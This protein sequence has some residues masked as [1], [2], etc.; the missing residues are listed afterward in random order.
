MKTFAF[1][2]HADNIRQVREFWPITRIVPDFFINRFLKN[3]D[4]KVVHIKSLKSSTNEEVQGYFI[5]S[6]ALPKT[7]ED[8]DMEHKEE[9]VLD[10]IITAG[11]LAKDLG[12]QI[13]GM[14]GYV[15][16]VAD[17]KPMIY[18]HVKI[19]ITSGTVFTAWSVIEAI[20]SKAIEKRID[21]KK[22]SLAVLG[23]DSS[24]GS[25]CARKLS[26][27]CRKIILTGSQKQK[28]ET[29]KSMI[30]DMSK[31]DVVI[32]EDSQKAANEADIVIIARLE[33]KAA[34]SI[35]SLKPQSIV[36]DLCLSKSIDDNNHAK[37]PSAVIE[38]G[39]V[40]LPNPVNMGFSLGL[41]K[42]TVCASLAET[43]LLTLEGKFS[44]YSL[45]DTINVDKLEELANI[46]VKHGFEVWTPDSEEA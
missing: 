25:L 14:G 46:A 32:E 29:L 21:L 6:P 31:A 33:Q 45:G 13:L 44:T 20:Y 19:P 10:K 8:I 30:N 22:S 4:F 15:S 16:F 7:D 18:K 40:K 42:D 43:I 1:L 41:P 34:F 38:G 24:L 23:A 9:L 12:A 37:K 2:F 17:K 26:E 36:C 28:L 3:Q 35:D 27:Y 39:L 11:F 5:A